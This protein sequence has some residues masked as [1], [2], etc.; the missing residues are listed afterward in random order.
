M[1][2]HKP[3]IM[4]PAGYWPQLHAAIEAGADAVYF[5]LHHFTARAKVGFTLSEL[6]DVMRTLHQ[7]G[8][9]GYVTFNTLVFDHEL[10]EAVR[11]LADIAAAGAD[12]IIV[13]D[14]AVAQLARQIAPDLAIHGST[15][16]SLTSAEGIN[17]A[18]QFGVSRVVLARELSLDDIRAIRAA[19]TCELEMFVHGALCVSYSGQCFSSEAWGGRSANRGQCAQACRLPYQMIVDDRLR[20]LDDARYLLS[21]GDL[22]AL[23]QMPDIVPLGVSALK[24][25]GRYKDADYVAL[26]T[27]A[28]RQA[29]DEAWAGRD[30]TI[31]PAEELQLQ[32]VYSRGFGPHF[33]TGT[34]HQAVVNGRSPNH[35]GVK[36]GVVS[37]VGRDHVLVRP[38]AAASAAPLKPGD[39]LVFD[40]ADW[41]SPA[42]PEEGGR[43]YQVTPVEEEKE[44]NRGGRGER[45]GVKRK[46]SPSSVSSV[47]SASSAPSAS[48]RLNPL[49]ELRFGNGQ[50]DFGRIRAGDWVWRTHD[51]DLDKAA[52]PYTQ[53]SQPVMKRPL[54]IHATAHEGQPLRL[55]WTLDE[56]PDI[57]VTVQSP[58]PLPAARNQALS[59]DFAH[60]QL[61]RLGNTPYELAELTLDVNGR[62]FAPSSLLNTLR[63]EAIDHLQ[64]LQ[65]APPAITLKDPTA[66]LHA[67]LQNPLVSNPQSPVSPSLHLLVRTPE[68]LEAAIALRPASI[69]LDYL[70]L[71]GLR[72]AVERVQAAGLEARVASPRILKPK[73]QRI[74][75]FLL[76]LNCPILVRSTGLLQAL[77]G[78]TSQPL[79]G[80]F[81]LNAAN[82]ITAR[83]FFELGLARLAPTHDLNAAQITTLA[84]T[85][86]AERL[87]VIAYHHLPVFHTEHC[88]FCRFLS[89]GTSYKDCGHP[90]EKHKVELRDVHGRSHP[91]M[92]DVG[93][94][95]TVFGAEAQTAAA[96]LPAWQAAGIVHYRLEFVHE[97]AEQVTQITAAFR[98]TLHGE[99]GHGELN[100]RL[101]Q[102]APQGTT[103]GSLFVPDDYLALPVLQ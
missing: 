25:E 23:Q 88:V 102:I 64:A 61:G 92:A 49:L 86:G 57:Q 96:H 55:V 24:I 18:Q 41:R 39:G 99:M 89:T 1:I 42:E 78:Q 8:V 21:P 53:A 90:C 93:C 6:P 7:R 60:E 103:E 75:N 33:V 51:P 100:G 17:L 65:A 69:T 26:T 98:L 15:Q 52:K 40:A 95:N 73:E 71:Y 2:N 43:V 48:P 80:D 58:E 50:I 68:Q 45:G 63:R 76:R 11:A 27:R 12:S 67:A 91:V 66:V 35:R 5:G 85:I 44:F 59:A 62:P 87:E 56:H 28:Y 72:P 9:K 54:S 14:V 84:Q 34:N 16:M 94:R 10:D 38:E 79:M 83:T 20:P 31:S 81:S 47:S 82:V 32:Q 37:Q 29:V 97:T 77:H 22:Y 19:T 46:T 30:L 13:Q 4:S 3:E 101:R 70:D 74:V 36:V